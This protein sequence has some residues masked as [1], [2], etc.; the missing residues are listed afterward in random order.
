MPVAGIFEVNVK[1]P[2]GEKTGILE[3]VV[4]NEVLSGTLTG[5]KG[6][7]DITDGTVSGGNISFNVNIDT[8]A[9]NMKAHVTGAVEGDVLTAIAQLP[10]GSLELSGLRNPSF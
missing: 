4:T 8:P 10:I 6:R 5:A 9:G 2:I 3:L 1:T 7:F